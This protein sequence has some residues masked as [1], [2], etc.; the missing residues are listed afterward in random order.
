M[1][2]ILEC[3]A[4]LLMPLLLG[5]LWELAAEVHVLLAA[6]VTLVTM[7]VWYLAGWR[8][9]KRIANPAAAILLGNSAGLLSLA[10]YL[11]MEYGAAEKIVWIQAAAQKF[12][13]PLTMISVRL[14]MRFSPVVDGVTQV[15]N[16][17]LQVVGLVL[18]AGLFT[19]GY[20]SGRQ[21]ARLTQKK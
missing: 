11:W 21:H 17:A 9:S 15:S 8:Y 6:L 13:A 16:T 5:W 1:I 7:G 2:G 3:A 18:M 4:Y 14:V 12:A 19:V 20:L 10:V